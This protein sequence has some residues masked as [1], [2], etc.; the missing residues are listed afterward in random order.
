VLT[1]VQH[2]VQD[3]LQVGVLPWL[4][5]YEPLLNLEVTSVTDLLY[6]GMVLFSAAI[7]GIFFS[8]LR[9]GTPVETDQNRGWGLQVAA[10]GVAGLL[11]GGVPF[12][13]S[14]LPVGL[15]FPYDRWTLAFM[16][17]SSLL[18]GGLIETLI[19][20][21][22]QRVI[23]AVVLMAFAVGWNFQISNTYRRDWQN[24]NT[25][26]WQ[27]AWRAPGIEPGTTLLTYDMPLAYYSDNSLSGV[28]SMAYADLQDVE[29][30]AGTDWGEIDYMLFYINDRIGGSLPSLAADTPVRKFYRSYLFEGNTSQS[31]V[32]FY[33]P[34]GCL[35]VIDPARPHE[36][37]DMPI[38]MLEAAHLGGTEV[39]LA[40]GQNA[41]PSISWFEDEPAHGWC[42]FY[43]QAD[44][45][46]QVEDWQRVVQLGDEALASDWPADLTE[47]G[48]FIEGYAR[49]GQAARA[50]ELSDAV[51]IQ[52]PKAAVRMCKTWKYIAESGMQGADSDTILTD[53][54]ERYAC[55]P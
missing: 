23:L 14:L 11:A 1:L 37:P 40:Q 10:L 8:L 12:W 47:L 18:L 44:L 41:T 24:L 15:D 26:M 32:Y 28:I 17:G 45:A 46:R 35:R 34:P 7:F 51:V 22:R 4:R 5:I 54:N 9:G 55:S 27:M 30:Q 39:I 21:W 48:V 52:D 16:L 31:L 19:H 38:T 43:E 49:A 3:F 20:T 42:Y 2:V 25:F 13:A 29:N 50:L 6:W 36:Y 33:S 53:V